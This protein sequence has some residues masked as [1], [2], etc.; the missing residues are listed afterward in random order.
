VTLGSHWI[1]SNLYSWRTE[2]NLPLIN[3]GSRITWTNCCFY[4]NLVPRKLLLEQ[5][6]LFWGHG[7]KSYKLTPTLS[8]PTSPS[9]SFIYSFSLNSCIICQRFCSLLAASDILQHRRRHKH[10]CQR[11][12]TLTGS[13]SPQTQSLE[14]SMKYIV[15]L[16]GFSVVM[17]GGIMNVLT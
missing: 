14:P 17:Y 7:N 12:D 6:V 3:N 11:P 2:H 13:G 9:T 8:S 10:C 1:C 15:Y 4:L 5:P 16:R